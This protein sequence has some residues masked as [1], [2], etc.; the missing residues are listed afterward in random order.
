MV[1]WL[2][3]AGVRSLGSY[4]L[5]SSFFGED[6]KVLEMNS[7]DGCTTVCMYLMSWKKSGENGNY[8]L[9]MVTIYHHYY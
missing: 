1:W 7:S 8:F 9:I 2:L 4:C 6:E 3:G 5:M